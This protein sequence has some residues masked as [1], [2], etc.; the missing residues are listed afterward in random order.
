MPMRDHHRRWNE[1]D[2]VQRFSRKAAPDF[3]RSETHFLDRIAA[4]LGSV[5]DV[6]CAAGRMMELLRH[7][8]AT[9]HFS[10]IDISDAS[11]ELA[12][13]SYPECTFVVENALEWETDER[14]DLV[15]ATGVCQHEPKFEKLIE[16]MTEW[17]DRY[18]L[19]DVKLSRLSEHLIDIDRA[20]CGGHDRLYYIVL[21]LPRLLDLL[22]T[23]PGVSSI[24]I[25]GYETKA[26]DR[27]VLPATLKP[28][29]SAGV[30]L[31]KS[32]RRGAEPVI[33]S[34]LPGSLVE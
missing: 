9:P 20:Y 28:L 5:L 19:F 14:F 22:T 12:K 29:V 32:D 3:F 17:S 23:L 25:F 1:K 8:G 34:D 2:S 6:G 33:E 10:G 13:R 18:V 24:S 31:T 30:L 26:N 21:A 7:Y 11:V 4:E 16:R 27:T 15:N